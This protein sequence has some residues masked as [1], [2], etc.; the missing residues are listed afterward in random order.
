MKASHNWMQNPVTRHRY[1]LLA[2]VNRTYQAYPNIMNALRVGI[3]EG[4][5]DHLD[6]VD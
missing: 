1:E 3:M 4:R 6:S 2:Q 5:L